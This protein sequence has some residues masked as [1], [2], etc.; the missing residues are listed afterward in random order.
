MAKTTTILGDFGP[1]PGV[2][3]VIKDDGAWNN[4]TGIVYIMGLSENSVPKTSSNLM[5]D[6]CFPH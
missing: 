2:S 4:K 6:P 3:V 1:E 5:D